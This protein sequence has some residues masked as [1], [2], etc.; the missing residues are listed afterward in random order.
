MQVPTDLFTS[1]YCRF[2]LKIGLEMLVGYELLVLY[3]FI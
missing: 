3:V 2:I 1:R